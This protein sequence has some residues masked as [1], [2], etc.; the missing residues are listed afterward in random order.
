MKL[1]QLTVV[2][3]VVLSIAVPSVPLMLLW[4]VY[5]V[6]RLGLVIDDKRDDIVYREFLRDQ[7]WFWAV[8]IAVVAAWLCL[9]WARQAGRSQA[10][11]SLSNTTQQPTGAPSGAGGC[12]SMTLG[13]PGALLDTGINLKLI[14]MDDDLIEVR[15]HASNGRFSA[16][17]D[18]YCGLDDIA[19]LAE[20]ARGFP[21][22]SEDRRELEIGTFDSGFAGG[23]AKL[24]LRCVDRA[25]HA[26]AD[27]AL[28]ADSRMSGRL[29]ETASFSFPVEPAG[30][31]DFVT[32][33]GSIP[34]VVGAVVSLRQAT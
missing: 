32:A 10:P 30:I 9:L 34:L 3:R 17:A 20:A 12:A 7:L 1:S 23:G 25:G 26:V 19:G 8:A 21:S 11:T 5:W 24:V 31:D 2:Q 29:A 33:L 14:W 13:R 28:R 6:K 16:T 4:P 15:V 22:S 18:C 27:V